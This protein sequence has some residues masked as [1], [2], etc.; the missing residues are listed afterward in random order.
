[1]PPL[2]TDQDFLQVN[3]IVVFRLAVHL[4]A[5]DNGNIFFERILI[6]FAD[7]DVFS[8]LSCVEM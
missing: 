1:M 2:M 4:K 3:Y 8:L 6:N 7:S 5:I